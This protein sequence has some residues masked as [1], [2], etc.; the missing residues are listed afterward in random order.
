MSPFIGKISCAYNEPN[1]DAHVFAMN[2][3]HQ[4]LY[5]YSGEEFG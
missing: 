5:Y 3:I 1:I 4:K 2:A